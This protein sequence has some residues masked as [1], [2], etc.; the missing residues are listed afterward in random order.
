MR[1]IKGIVLKS[2][3]AKVYLL[4][5]GGDYL[6]LPGR[7]CVYEAGR[8]IELDYPRPAGLSRYVAVAAVLIVLTL[9]LVLYA[10][11]PRHTAYLAMDINPGLLLSLD[12]HAR[13]LTAKGLN[14]D[15]KYLLKDLSIYG[16]SAEAAT[17]AIFDQAY[18]AG[19]LKASNDNSI[20]I[21]LAAPEHYPVSA[22]ELRRTASE[23]I[24]A[25][26]IGSYV[27]V[28]TMTMERASEAVKNNLSINSIALQD[29]L[30]DRGVWEES[31]GLEDE[32][33][34]T[35]PVGA[36]QKKA[37]NTVVFKE[38]EF[39]AGDKTT[40]GPPDHSGPPENT[41]GPGQQEADPPGAT[42]AQQN[43]DSGNANDS[44]RRRDN[45]QPG[46]YNR[47]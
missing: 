38:D 26:A 10:T 7:G 40:G 33:G 41:P 34:L 22:S 39:I 16:M 19:Y 23:K 2:E 47:N 43:S 27:K 17:A 29:E 20:F 6:K 31:F 44:N 12:Q 1:K 3:P 25:L 35:P 15:G 13:V 36:I 37:G 21:A 9:S 30:T 45:D 4:T 14:N 46:R 5:P 8:E 32:P 42:E 28:Q 11:A 24:S 18:Q